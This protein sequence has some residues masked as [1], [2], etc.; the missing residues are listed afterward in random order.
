MVQGQTVFFVVALRAGIETL[1]TWSSCWPALRTLTSFVCADLIGHR[2][3]LGSL[4]VIIGN[5]PLR[6]RVVGPDADPA[7]V[8]PSSAASSRIPDVVDRRATD[9]HDPTGPSAPCLS[10]DSSADVCYAQHPLH[11]QQGRCGQ[12]M[13]A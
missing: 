8:P 6:V 11:R 5:R 7:S 2:S 12:S 3:S 10:C 13:L 9:C 4:P 1:Y